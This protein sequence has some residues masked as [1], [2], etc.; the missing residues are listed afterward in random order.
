MHVPTYYGTVGVLM[1]GRQRRARLHR[2]VVAWIAR[3]PRRRRGRRG[4][5]GPVVDPTAAA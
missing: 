4:D 3:M 2:Y 5:C 1:G